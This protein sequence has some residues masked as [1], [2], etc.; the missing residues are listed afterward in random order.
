MNEE[1]WKIH[2]SLQNL[3]EGSWFQAGTLP[4][5][6]SSLEGPRMC[7]VS[8]TGNTCPVVKPHE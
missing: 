1:E 7:R 8:I 6:D 5:A 4:L 3:H 2:C